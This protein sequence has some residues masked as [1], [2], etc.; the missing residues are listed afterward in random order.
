MFI[1]VI[2]KGPPRMKP[3]YKFKLDPDAKQP[4]DMEHL[5]LKFEWKCDDINERHFAL[6]KLREK[7]EKRLKA[8]RLRKEME[9][10]IGNQNPISGNEQR[11]AA[12]NGFIKQL[13]S[14]VDDGKV[15]AVMG[16]F[17]KMQSL[18]G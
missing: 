10:A 4:D 13:G 1:V 11:I 14:F 8:M 16:S 2:R 18:T 12:L 5:L 9:V 3:A 15:N 7:A 17:R 6:L